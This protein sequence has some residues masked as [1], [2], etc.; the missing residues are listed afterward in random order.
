MTTKYSVLLEQY[1]EVISKDQM[2]RI[3]HISK[4][5]ATWLLENGVIPCQDSGKK[6]RRFQIKTIDIVKYLA[7]RDSSPQE[8]STPVGI[9]NNPKPNRKTV[10]PATQTS[11]LSLK[12]YLNL[13][14]KMVPDALETKDISR[15][16]GYTPQTVGQWI[17]KK[18]LQSVSCPNGTR[19]AKEWLIDFIVAY[20]ISHPAYLSPILKEMREEFINSQ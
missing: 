15:I 12:R 20:I 4:R 1:P 7:K 5:K 19:I 13:K 17:S 16:T 2:Y 6:T 9:F 14:W 3:C 10:V 18:K 11:H 8:V